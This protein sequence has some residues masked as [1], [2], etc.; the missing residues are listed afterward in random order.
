LLAMLGL[1]QAHHPVSLNIVGA[2]AVQPVNGL[3]IVNL[4]GLDAWKQLQ[5][6]AVV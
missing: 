1:Q 4:G 3:D 2:D 5:T 6:L